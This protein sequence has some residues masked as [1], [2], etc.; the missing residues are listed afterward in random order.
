VLFITTIFVSGVLQY[1]GKTRLYNGAPRSLHRDRLL[2][3]SASSFEDVSATDGLQMLLMHIRKFSI[4][5]IR[6][7]SMLS[8]FQLIIICFGLDDS[9]A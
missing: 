1:L 7:F 4:I 6:T 9:G 5:I 3:Q 8:S 2:Y